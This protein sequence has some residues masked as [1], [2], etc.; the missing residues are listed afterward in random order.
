MAL[1]GGVPVKTHDDVL[2]VTTEEPLRCLGR[3]E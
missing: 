3:V 2:V 1:N